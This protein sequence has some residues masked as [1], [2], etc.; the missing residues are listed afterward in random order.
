MNTAA[1]RSGNRTSLTDVY[2]PRAGG[3]AVTTATSYQ[4]DWAD[5]LLSATVT[6]PVGGADSITDGLAAADITYDAAGNTTKLGDVVLT[7]DATGRHAGST[8]ADGTTTSI[9][10][11]ADGRV[12]SR[13]VD[14]LGA[15]AGDAAATTTYLYSA[16]DDVP[17]ATKTGDVLTRSIA[18]PGGVSV[19]LGRRHPGSTRICSA[20]RS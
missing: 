20:T 14:P 16:G 4:Y 5:R 12:V 13:T 3:P 8:Y 19:S 7:Y 1:G 15:I 10:R 18:L 11:D 6:N 2:T 9:A 17:F